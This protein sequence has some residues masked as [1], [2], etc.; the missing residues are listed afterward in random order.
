MTATTKTS[1]KATKKLAIEAA[2]GLPIMQ[3][4]ASAVV[5]SAGVRLD[6]V[7]RLYVEHAGHHI[8]C[9]PGVCR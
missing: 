6:E 1:K 5:N 9:D 8:V 7:S 2:A 4:I 3:A